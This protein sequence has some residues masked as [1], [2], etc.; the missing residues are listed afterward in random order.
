MCFVGMMAGEQGQPA[1]D[2]FCQNDPPPDIVDLRSYY[3]LGPEYH[4]ARI[5]GLS[6]G[7]QG[8]P[9]ER[10]FCSKKS[11]NSG[12]MDAG[13]RIEDSMRWRAARQWQQLLGM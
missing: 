7:F 10:Y 3:G 1:G 11:A 12:S 5:E 9:R 6:C 13:S 8:T 2:E 4:I